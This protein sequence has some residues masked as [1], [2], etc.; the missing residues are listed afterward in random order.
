MKDKRENKAEGM[1]SGG[2]NI[3]DLTNMVVHKYSADRDEPHVQPAGHPDIGARPTMPTNVCRLAAWSSTSTALPFTYMT[4]SVSSLPL[5]QVLQHPL[6]S[7]AAPSSLPLPVDR[8]TRTQ[9]GVARTKQARGEA[10]PVSEEMTG[11]NS[12]DIDGCSADG[13]ITSQS[14]RPCTEAFS[15]V[16]PYAGLSTG[17]QPP[18]VPSIFSLHHQPIFHFPDTPSL[19][20]P[21]LTLSSGASTFFYLPPLTSHSCMQQSYQTSTALHNAQAS[22][23][24]SGAT[25]ARSSVTAAL[26][27]DSPLKAMKYQGDMNPAFNCSPLLYPAAYYPQSFR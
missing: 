26:T 22:S 17:S 18:N 9:D 16:Q 19:I 23:T 27:P 6:G 15:T 1:P 11:D 10:S 21:S 13:D 20:S 14:R 7:F 24:L 12:S 8:L 2:I 25:P 3:R 5:F 4:S